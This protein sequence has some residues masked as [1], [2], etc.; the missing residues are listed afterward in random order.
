MVLQECLG[1]VVPD[2]IVTHPVPHFHINTK[3]YGDS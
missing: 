3:I 2:R 1:D